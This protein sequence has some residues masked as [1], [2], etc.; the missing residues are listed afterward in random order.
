[1]FV[2]YNAIE[3]KIMAGTLR[4]VW[5]RWKRFGKRIGDLQA[6]ALLTVFYFVLLSPFALA[7]RRW[8]DPLAIKP[9][10]AKG[11]GARPVEN[12]TAR[13]RANRQF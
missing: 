6:R 13:E 1:M 3:K 9:G 10:A 12:G 8:S 11:W 2:A 7:L 5:K 4:M